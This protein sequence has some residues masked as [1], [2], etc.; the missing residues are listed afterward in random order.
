MQ[1]TY[2]LLSALVWVG[3]VV[4]QTNKGGI[5]GTVFDQQGAV[6][7]AAT[8]T[9][10]NVGTNESIRLTSSESGA[11]SAPLLDP[12][13][14]RVT[15]ETAGFKK[16][17][18][19]KIKVDTATVASVNV[20]LE[21]GPVTTEIT[22]SASPDVLTADS[23]AVGQTITE[24][25]IA[26][27]PLNNRSVLDLAL[28]AANVSGVAGTEDPELGSEI[29]A[30][31]FNVNVNGGRAGSTSILAD[32]ANNTGVGLGRAIVTFSPDTV[33]EFTVQTSNFS[34]EFGQ[35]GGGVINMTTKSGTNRYDG[36]LYWYHRNPA[37]NA[38]PYTTSTNNRPESNRRQHQFGF[39]LGGPVRLPRKLF[40][41]FSYD[42]HNRTFFFVAIEP[43]YY[44][45]GTQFT[46]LLP[47]DATLKGDLS[48]VVAVNGGYAPR[49]VAERFGLQNQVRDATIYNQFDVL[50]NGIFQRRTLGAGETYPPFPNNQIPSSMLDSLSQG[51]LKYLPTA[52]PYFLS[53]GNL[54]NYASVS[55]IKNLEKRAT[56][57]LDHHITQKNRLS[58]RYTQVPVRGD[59]GRGDFQVGRD[60]VNTGGTD[61][62]WSK[63]VLLTDTHVFGAHVFN[64]LRLNYTYGRFT[65]NFPPM[66]D[67]NNGRNLARELGLPSLTKG[68]VPEFTTGAGSIG[69]SQSQQNE[70]AEHSYGITDSLSWVRGPMTMKFGLDLQQR[71]LKTIP[72]YGASGGRYEF[73][74]NRTLSNNNGQSNGTGGIEFAQFLLGVYNLATLREVFIPYYYQW[75]SAAGFIQNDWKV[76]PNLTLNLG[77]R[78][79]LDLPRTE[80][81]DRQGV[82]L[83]E[84][85][86]AYPIPQPCT[87]CALPNGKTVT[88]ALVIPFGYSGR[89][90]RSRYIFPPE[91]TNFEPRLGF[92]Y[93]PRLFD[94]NRKGKVVFRGGWG[95]SHAPLTGM[96]RNPSPDFA[97]GTT[98]FNTI[99]NR[100]EHP[101]TNIVA[102]LC[103][104]KP[105][106]SPVTPEQFLQ[107]PED[108]LVYL[109]AVNIPGFAVSSNTHVPYVQSW[110]ATLS[111][112]APQQ[113]VVELGYVGAKGTHLFLP[114]AYLNPIPF[115]LT[116]AYV[117]LGINPLT[118]VNDPLGRRNATGTA[119]YQFAQGYLGSQ[120]FGYQ[121]LTEAYDSSANSIRHAATLRVQR[122]HTKGLSYLANYTFGKSIDEASDAGD[123][124]FVNLNVRSP[125]HVN[126]GASRSL[127]R[128]V[129]TFDIKHVFSV[130]SLYDL[131]FGRRRSFLRSA[132]GWADALV[133]GWSLSGIGRIQGGIPMVVVLRDDNGFGVSGNAR[134]IRPDV[135][136]GVP[137]LNPNWSRACPIGAGCEPYYNP[138]AFMRPAK[139]TLGNA[140]RTFDGARSPAQ[141]FLDLSVQKNFSLGGE[142]RRRLQ[143]RVD[144]IN[145]FNHPVFRTGRLED[146]GEI[147]AAP[148]ESTISNAEYDAWAAAATGRPARS[149]S[150]GA[151]T[152][153]QINSIITSARIPGTGTLLRDFFHIQL[154]AGFYSMNPN[155]F[156]ITTPEGLKLYRMRQAYTSDRW[157]YLDV[158]TGRS[159][160]TPRFIQIAV[161]FYF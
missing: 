30:P 17:V 73:N 95:L 156:D 136:P 1:R 29:P 147:F 56:V 130:S 35:T 59:R 126:F 135:V 89:G 76:R 11:F 98:G 52:G 51:L 132:P 158:A 39:T 24:R 100:I 15:V 65:R 48:N 116:E 4:A 157:G 45:D 31:G 122:R 3:A 27:M 92:A 40:G 120:Y 94:W 36:L 41:P 131:P 108:G 16:A 60:E 137:L 75:S 119:V 32:G 69:W 160:Y 21:P 107:I 105:V 97:S 145:V 103:C 114:P 12:V 153:A 146:A 19:E 61:Y 102:R 62:S 50:P 33:Q 141:H 10:T 109:N 9:I 91:K 22:V 90:G 26:E 79:A 81:Y 104:N 28:T 110:S 142:G 84:L 140:P 68:G 37:L 87:I 112:E 127:D 151:A 83:P 72:M 53:D 149:T 125:G 6:I 128:S 121:G 34:A 161:K 154:P 115:D 85:A 134:A 8:V 93:V 42:G 150:A 58:G 88:S 7:P 71:R 143:L 57:R 124:R 159:G 64:E 18:I 80:K 144:A 152:L 155:S 67:A 123:V 111:F 106:I 54:V 77:L 63:Q 78:Y 47:T 20:T 138:A 44:Y 2:I 133:G 25:Q 46:S 70:N 113:T 74:R 82:F 96:N 38:A 66:F 49:D 23:G 118:N 117:G 5:S 86:K 129:S 99:D 101:G 14:Y 13:Y 55:F 43:R 139:A 148:S